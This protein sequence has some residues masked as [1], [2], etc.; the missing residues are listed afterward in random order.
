MPTMP[1]LLM[2]GF[3]GFLGRTRNPSWDG[4]DAIRQ[5]PDAG[6]LAPLGPVSILRL[7]V[8][9]GEAERLL[10]EAV[11]SL[12]PEAL[13][14]LG[15]HGGPDSGGRGA[16]SFYVETLAHNLDDSKAPDNAGEVREARPIAAG[17]TPDAALPATLPADWLLP[18]LSGAGFACH[19]SRD[20]GR[21]LCNHLFFCA[22]RLAETYS[23]RPL[24]AF[25]HVPPSEEMREGSLPADQ[26][27]V[28]YAALARAVLDRIGVHGAVRLQ[29]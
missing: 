2:T 1:R 29:G 20:A 19:E 9:Y 4:L 25:V 11:A 23:P 18:A 27:P 21:Y 10:A 13:V 6:L 14:M 26:F 8:R 28:A 7:P 22:L 12:R 15:M 16:K 3:E 5:G 17:M 24:T